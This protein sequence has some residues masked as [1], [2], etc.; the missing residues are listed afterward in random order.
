MKVPYICVCECGGTIATCD[1]IDDY[2]PDNPN[3]L[4]FVMQGKCFKCGAIYQWNEI[5]SFDRVENFKKMLDRPPN[6]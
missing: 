3:E 2:L 5:F 4:G 1:T 6:V